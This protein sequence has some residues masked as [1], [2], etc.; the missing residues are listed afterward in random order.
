MVDGMSVANRFVI[1]SHI[2]KSACVSHHSAFSY[3]GYTNQ[4]FNEVYVSSSSKFNS[5]D[6]DGVTFRYVM[7]RINAGVEKRADGVAVTDLERTVID[8]INDFEK[9]GGLEELLRSL[10]MVPYADEDRLLRYLESYDKQ[11]L[12]QK[13]GYILEHF[14]KEMSVS[15]RFF[16]QCAARL[17]KSVRYL[18]SGPVKGKVQ[19]DKRWQLLVPND[20]LSILLEGGDQF[21]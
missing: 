16:E 1:A 19:Y 14:K 11:V 20:L 8:G 3:Y 21:A 7:A 9:I 15:E 4:V 17:S 5:F 12:Y 10:A 2:T 18:S 6:F 13:T